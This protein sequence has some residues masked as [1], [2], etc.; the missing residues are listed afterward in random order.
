M[1]T[2]NDFPAITST[3]N[4]TKGHIISNNTLIPFT[5]AS[6]NI[7]FRINR[8]VFLLELHTRSAKPERESVWQGHKIDV[9]HLAQLLVLF[10][11]I[12]RWHSSRRISLSSRTL[13][14][15]EIDLDRSHHLVSR[16]I[17]LL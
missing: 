1:K 15:I 2:L 3:K 10:F 9:E 4:F 6:V 16:T 11:N 14:L 5:R 17:R 13:W 8:D 7:S 12:L